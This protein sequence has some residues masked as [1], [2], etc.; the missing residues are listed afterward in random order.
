MP[1]RRV[2]NLPQQPDLSFE[3]ALWQ[4]GCLWVA[5]IDEAGRG[6]LA[7][8]VSAAAVVL[9][10][11]PAL[12]R[13]L[14]GVRDSKLMTASQRGTWSQSIRQQA[15]SWAVGF[16]GADEIDRLGIV[17][18]T[19]LAAWRAVEQLVC[20]PGHLLLDWLFLPEIELPQTALVKGDRRSL[21]IAAASV[22]AKTARDALLVELDRQ[23]PGY[24]LARHK[25]YGT[26][27]HLEALQ[28]LG[29]APVHRR[30]YQPVRLV[31]TRELQSEVG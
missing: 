17:P 29:P 30:S 19:R 25:G 24:G 11:D 4:A 14:S 7:G 5:G 3:L 31:E 15:V 18:A 20:I 26:A 6:A 28:H 1:P 10:A 22:L 12:T 21:S 9:P 23:Y 16:A 8:P 2:H 27:H 13:R